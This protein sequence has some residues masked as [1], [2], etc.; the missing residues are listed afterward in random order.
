MSSVIEL[1]IQLEQ[2]ISET[3]KQLSIFNTDLIK[4]NIGKE[5]FTIRT[6][7]DSFSIKHEGIKPLSDALN[8]LISK[9]EV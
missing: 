2:K 6:P 1:N 8:F 5:L 7:Y 9:G 4:F 3:N